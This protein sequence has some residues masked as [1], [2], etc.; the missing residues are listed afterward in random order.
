MKALNSLWV[1]LTL[2]FTLVTLLVVGAIAFLINRSTSA[3]F[4][5]YITRSEVTAYGTEQLAA[6]YVAHDGWEGIESLLANGVVVTGS[7][8]MPF[9]RRPGMSEMRL[10]VVLADANGKVVFDSAGT[11]EGKKLSANELKEA[12]L[13]TEFGSEKALGYM[14]IALPGAQWLGSPEQR[15]LDKTRSLLLVVAAL[16]IVLGLL[17]GALFS[18]SLTA[19]LQRL[20]GAARAV[21]SGDLGK[22]VKV[23]GSAEI[24]DVS[25]AFNEMTAALEKGEELRQ[26]LM[27]DVAHEL[28]TPLSVL[29]GNLRA[30]LDDVYP[31][32]KAEIAR[33]YDETRLLNLLVEDLRELAQAEAG[34]LHFNRMPTDVSKI[35]QSAVARFEPAAQSKSI[36][37]ELHAEGDLPTVT[38]D[39]DRMAQ[40]MN[41]LMTNALRHTPEGGRITVSAAAVKDAVEVAVTDSGEGIKAEDLPHIFDRFWR[42]D[43]SR[44]RAGGGSGL[45]LA[46]V[47]ALVEAHGG[48]VQA[49]SDGPG[50]GSVFAF[51]LPVAQT[52]DR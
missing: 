34:Q 38:A 1:R 28:R 40:V 4:R 52:S 13:V 36:Q 41:N 44:S 17:I 31:L 43:R 51:T 42:V 8:T 12:I 15:F 29:Q 16:A 33:L 48:T 10:D 50:L 39:P 21:G 37:V 46:I 9:G 19:P 47:R 11:T 27:S 30:L 5:R 25:R 18:R 35:L 20:A 22:R 3:E 26:N 14:L 2:I 23:E 24:A 45:G 49:A 6:Y 32:E 7:R